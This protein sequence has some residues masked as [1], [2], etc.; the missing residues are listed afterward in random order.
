MPQQAILCGMVCHTQKANGEIRMSYY[1]KFSR[2]E[3]ADFEAF[4]R[5]KEQQG[6]NHGFEPTF[7]PSELFDC[8]EA[9]TVYA[10]EKGRAAL[11]E[12]CGLG[13]SVQ[14]LTWAQ[15]V[16]EHTNKPVLVL[17]PLAVG[18]QMVREAH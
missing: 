4:I 14:L 16:V 13:K 3:D 15:N 2:L 8:Q 1:N 10:I 11:F 12:D 17:T 6:S 18:G 5:A 9:M 7:M